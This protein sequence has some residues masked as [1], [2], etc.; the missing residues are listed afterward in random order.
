MGYRTGRISP[1]EATKAALA[2]I[3]A[4]EPKLNAMYI[5]DAEGALAQAKAAETR[6]KKGTALRPLAGVP[7]TI[8]DNIS[9]NGWPPPDSTDAGALTARKSDVIGTRV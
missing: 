4:W 3:A 8:Q 7:I 1:V 9:T 6:R 5:T 2:R